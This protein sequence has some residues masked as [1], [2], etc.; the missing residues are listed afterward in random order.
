MSQALVYINAH[1]ALLEPIVFA[2]GTL[3]N[4]PEGNSL[5]N[6]YAKSAKDN[7]NTILRIYSAGILHGKFES[8]LSQNIRRII[9][10]I[11][12]YA[13]G[14]E[15]QAQE[16]LYFLEEAVLNVYKDALKNAAWC[17]GVLEL[18]NLEF[19]SIYENNYYVSRLE[20][21]IQQWIPST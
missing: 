13:D 15:E 4:T 10:E 1:V 21:R 8:H 18:D 16:D 5:I 17:D 2:G 20:T 9:T 6:N 7:P 11:R 3:G 14:R 12:T 19:R